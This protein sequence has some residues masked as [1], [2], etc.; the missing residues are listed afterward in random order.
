MSIQRMQQQQQQQQYNVY[1]P[2]KPLIQ[3]RIKFRQQIVQIKKKSGYIL[4]KILCN[5]IVLQMQAEYI[6]NFQL[7]QCLFI[8]TIKQYLQSYHTTLLQFDKESKCMVGK[9]HQGC[10]YYCFNMSPQQV[11][12]YANITANSKYSNSVINSPSLFLIQAIQILLLPFYSYPYPSQQAIVS[13]AAY[14]KHL[15]TAAVATLAAAGLYVSAQGIFG[16]G[17]DS[18]FAKLFSGSSENQYKYVVLGGGNAAG[19]AARQFLAKG[20]K[21]GELCIISEEPYAAYERPA[22]SKAYLFPN[23]PARLPGFHTCVGGG[24]ERQTP[25]WYTQKGVEFKYNTKVVKADVKSKKLT[26]ADGTEFKYDKMIVATGCRPLTLADFKMKGADNPNLYYLRNVEDANI[27]IEAIKKAKTGAKGGKV[28]ALGGGYIGMETAAAL[29]MNGLKV[30][31]VFPE[32]H[33]MPRLFTPKIAEFYTKYYNNKGIDIQH[34]KLAASIEPSD[35]G[36]TAVLKDGSKMDADIIV[37]G[38]GAR[39]NTELFKDQLKIE[40]GGIKVDSMMKTSNPDVYAVGDVA[41]FPLKMYGNKVQRQEH[42]QN[43]RESAYQAVNSIMSSADTKP[44]DYLPYFYSR[45][46]DLSWKFFGSSDGE[47]IHFG[48][49]STPPFGAYWVKDGKVVGVFMEGADGKATDAMKKVAK[50]RPAYGSVL[51]LEKKG[52]DFAIAQL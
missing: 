17:K 11:Q 35:G 48:N 50:E 31:M 41:A 5:K 47:V 24:G 14:Q 45:V 43:C 20:V 36:V 40:A 21:P 29:E 9:Y 49:F 42:V 37:V 34:H 10:C 44:Y 15:P 13:M 46:Y 6:Y 28:L 19:Y 26:S 7:V 2:N 39:A 4:A 22:L 32:D 1:S 16:V 25:E 51:E 27:L 12:M 52:I 38:V 8:L 33:L 3:H 23:K 18:Y 30:T